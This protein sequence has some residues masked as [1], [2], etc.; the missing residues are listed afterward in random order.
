MINDKINEVIHGSVTENVSYWQNRLST[1]Q[2]RI[3]TQYDEKLHTLLGWNQ[4]HAAKHYS[5]MSYMKIIIIHT[6]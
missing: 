1:A 4:K 2:Y 3:S 6:C 5:K